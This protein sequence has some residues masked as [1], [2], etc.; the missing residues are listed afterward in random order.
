MK[1]WVCHFVETDDT[2]KVLWRSL[3]EVFQSAVRSSE[4]LEIWILRF[5]DQA[6]FELSLSLPPSTI[7]GIQ[8]S[9]VV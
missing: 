3:S 8:E 4:D 7:T 2:P 1:Y 6:L 5:V 9:C